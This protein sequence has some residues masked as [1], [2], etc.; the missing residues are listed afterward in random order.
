M[1]RQVTFQ[2]EVQAG[3]GCRYTLIP[4]TTLAETNLLNAEQFDLV[5]EQIKKIG[6]E[7]RVVGIST[8]IP[9]EGNATF[10]V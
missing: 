8:S 3:Y 1:H 5:V 10:E 2:L 4:R 7:Y 6:C 9:I